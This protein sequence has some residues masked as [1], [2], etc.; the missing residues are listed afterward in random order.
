MNVPDSEKSQRNGFGQL[1][2]FFVF[3]YVAHGLAS[4]F[5]LVA[6]PMQFF[7]MEQLGLTAAEISAYLSVMM[8][9]WVLKPLYG[10]LCDFVPL[11]G[12]R[13]KSYLV[14]ANAISAAALVA[15][16]FATSTVAIVGALLAAAVGVAA[17]TAVASGLAAEAGA[18]DGRSSHY[19]SLQSF[20][21]YAALLISSLAGGYLCHTLSP[22]ASLTV[23]AAVAAVPPLIVS[24]LAALM[25]K[26]EK[27]QFNKP[28]LVATIQSLRSVTRSR[29]FWMVVLFIWLWDF[30]PSFGVP[31]YFYESK[32]LGFSQ[33]FIGQ[34]GA[35]NAVG[36]MVGAL[37]YRLWFGRQGMNHQ[38]CYAITAGVAS[39]LGFLLLSSAFSAIVLELCRGVANMVAVLVI[40]SLAAKVCPPRAAVSMMA[41]LIAVKNLAT[42]VAT[43]IGGY[44]FTVVFDNQLA[45]L[46]VVAAGVTALCAFLVPFLRVN[47]QAEDDQN[48][49]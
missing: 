45:P 32:T 7:M 2:W 46:V 42:E 49:S 22:T 3:A 5:G 21:Y 35:W 18:N 39:T 34:L 9:P 28:V 6:Q 31:L 13:R 47:N 23:A 37:V 29:V 14:L 16:A 8:L 11:F 36:M 40:Y 20:C 24:V 43:F 19:F 4:Q 33:G 38:L 15:M 1:T 17:S 12:Y 27:A 48:K 41:V 30:S 26:E 25:L 10:M 44:L